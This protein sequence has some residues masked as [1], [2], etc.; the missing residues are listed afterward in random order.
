MQQPTEFEARVIA[1]PHPM[2]RH[3]WKYAGFLKL[4]NG[5][6]MRQLV[7][8]GRNRRSELLPPFNLPREIG[9]SRDEVMVIVFL[10]KYVTLTRNLRTDDHHHLYSVKTNLFGRVDGSL[11]KHGGGYQALFISRMPGPLFGKELV[12]AL[13]KVPGGWVL[14]HVPR[15]YLRNGLTASGLKANSRW[16]PY[17]TESQFPF[18]LLPSVYPVD[19]DRCYPWGKNDFRTY[20]VL[21]G[22]DFVSS[23]SSDSSEESSDDGSVLDGEGDN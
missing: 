9:I 19:Y 13:D 3:V 23:D 8:E 17:E 18:K 15:F 22:D 16:N 20:P 14:E 4:R 11:S 21:E 2:I 5:R 12:T 6:W 7:G 10:G 1:L